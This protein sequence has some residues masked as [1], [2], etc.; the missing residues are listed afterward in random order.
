MAAPK[1]NKFALGLT[2][3]GVPPMYNDPQ[4]MCEKINEYFDSLLIEKEDE[5]GEKYV[6]FSINP[7]ITGVALYLGFSSRQSLYDYGQKDDFS[8]IIKRLRLVIESSYE[9]MLHTKTSTGAI[10][11]L[12]NMGWKDKIETESVNLNYS[13][14]VSKKEAKEISEALEDEC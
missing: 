4:E 13:T 6:A 9:E 2:T 8:Y 12:K 11:A 14:E 10:F 1:G 3:N 5:N 7:T